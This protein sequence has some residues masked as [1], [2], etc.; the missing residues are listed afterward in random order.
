MNV[1][2]VI[3]AAVLSSPLGTNPQREPGITAKG[4]GTLVLQLRWDVA[5][6]VE[7]QLLRLA[8]VVDPVQDPAGVWP[9]V[10]DTVVTH[11][12]EGWVT[13]GD[14]MQRL[15]GAGLHPERVRFEGPGMCRLTREAR[16]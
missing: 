16:P 2:A 6:P 4:G 12:T 3:V 1:L 10:S 11:R 8:A 5:A 7:G 14:L 9:L 15:R 13:W